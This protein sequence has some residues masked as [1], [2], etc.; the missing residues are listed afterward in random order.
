MML[1]LGLSGGV[2]SSVAAVL[3]HKAIGDQ[4]NC[5]FVDT[6]LLRLNEADEIKSVFEKHFGIKL[7]CVDA[8]QHFYQ[9]L[10]GVNDPEE[11]RKIIGKEFIDVFEEQAAKLSNIQMACTRYHLFRCD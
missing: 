5:V 7:I 4:L 8:K 9:A 2:D 3:L 1:L 10:L 11:K 6:G